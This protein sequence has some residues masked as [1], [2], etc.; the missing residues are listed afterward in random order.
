LL[1]RFLVSQLEITASE[2]FVQ[3]RHRNAMSASQRLHGWVFA[4]SHDTNHGFVIL[5]ELDLAVFCKEVPPQRE[6]RDSTILSALAAATNSASGVDQLTLVCR[7]DTA[8][9]GNDELGPVQQ[10]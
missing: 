4:R 5:S 7:F 2:P 6:S 8:C 9:I 3:P 10:R 1:I